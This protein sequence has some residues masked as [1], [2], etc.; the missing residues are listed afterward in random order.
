MGKEEEP[1]Y[2]DGIFEEQASIIIVNNPFILNEAGGRA[3]AITYFKNYEDASPG[4]IL[5]QDLENKINETEV[6]EKVEKDKM[7]GLLSELMKA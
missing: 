2:L 6:G 7:E 5:S 1:V 4:E 3:A